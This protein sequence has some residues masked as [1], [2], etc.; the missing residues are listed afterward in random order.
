MLRL[1]AKKVLADIQ[2]SRERPSSPDA[3]AMSEPSTCSSW[4][5]RGGSRDGTEGESSYLLI[6]VHEARNLVA[7]DYETNS[8]DP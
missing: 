1:R 3:D 6:H 7:K 2:T 8:S 5:G 4:G